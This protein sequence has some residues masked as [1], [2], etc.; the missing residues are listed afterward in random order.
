MNPNG[1][2]NPFRLSRR[3][4][5]EIAEDL[6][7]SYKR[8]SLD[9]PDILFTISF[10]HLYDSLIYPEYG[11]SLEEGED[12]GE[13]DGEKILGYY[14]YTNN[15]IVLDAI[16]DDRSQLIS[17]KK[18]FTAWHELGH[19][20]LHGAWLRANAAVHRDARVVT[21]ESSFSSYT[22]DRLERQANLLAAHAA[23]PTWFLDYV[24]KST[25]RLARPIEF[26]GPYEYW[27]EVHGIRKLTYAENFRE[28]CLGIARQIQHRFGALSI[29]SLSYRVE[30]SVWVSDV[31]RAYSNPERLFR[32]IPVTETTFV[33]CG[34]G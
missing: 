22:T 10:D 34:A 26:R 21:C 1:V 32:S 27:L 6:S 28:L 14:D 12:L 5:V 15:V 19:A 7:I 33:P 20:L 4:I 13:V 30:E 23:A 18:A 16:L 29:E 24:L 3:R 25:F 17:R 8:M 9:C 31:T 11:I 2:I